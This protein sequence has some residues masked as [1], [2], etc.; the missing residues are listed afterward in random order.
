[1]A[2][3]Y[4]CRRR[5]PAS[6]PAAALGSPF[7]SSESHREADDKA[8][9]LVAAADGP[10]AKPPESRP[11]LRGLPPCERLQ[12]YLPPRR[13]YSRREL[14]A[15]ACVNSTG[16]V[17]AWP[18]A[19][20]LGY[21]TLTSGDPF[22]KQFCYSLHGIGLVAMLN[23]SWL[24]HHLA[25][26]WKN[27]P[28]VYSPLDQVGI[29]TMIIGCFAPLMLAVD[30]YRV[31]WCVCM[32]GLVGLVLQ[33]LRLARMTDSLRPLSSRKGARWTIV[34]W[35]NAVHYLLMGL[36]VLPDMPAMMEVLPPRTMAGIFAGGV[37]Y[38][39]GVPFL[40]CEQLEF[41]QTY[42]HICVVLGA[43]CF[44]TVNVL[45]VMDTAHSVTA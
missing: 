2:F 42:W 27:A 35:I 41:H 32:L 18:C 25:W 34:D 1:M 17:L 21:K 14:L 3:M 5:A 37:L 39:V 9:K 26:D 40:L 29:N 8:A 4:C 15:D 19:L 45:D 24:Y 7:L 13:P 11:K 43:M 31:L 16:A 10:A 30:G 6:C 44:Y 22:L 20:L 36:L 28:R 23:L 12:W 33:V 38:I